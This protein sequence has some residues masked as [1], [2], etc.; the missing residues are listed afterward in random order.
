MFFGTSSWSYLILLNSDLKVTEFFRSKLEFLYF[1]NFNIL[2]KI[3][4][5]ERKRTVFLIKDQFGSIKASKF[6]SNFYIFKKYIHLYYF[7]AADFE[8]PKWHFNW[9]LDYLSLVLLGHLL[10]CWTEPWQPVNNNVQIP[11]LLKRKLRDDFITIYYC[12]KNICLQKM[13]SENKELFHLPN[14]DITRFNG[15]RLKHDKEKSS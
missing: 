2:K 14:K 13:P 15:W 8:I 4:K 9:R 3:T 12:A 5:S 1:R 10:K 7:Y 11:S 6:N